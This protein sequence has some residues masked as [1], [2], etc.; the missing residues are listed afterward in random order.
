MPLDMKHKNI[1]ATVSMVRLVG[2]IFGDKSE[3]AEA[4][5]TKLFMAESKECD[6]RVAEAC[7]FNDS[8]Q[9]NLL[10]CIGECPLGTLVEQEIKTTNMLDIEREV[11]SFGCDPESGPFPTCGRRI[12]KDY[13]GRRKYWHTFKNTIL[14]LIRRSK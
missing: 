1:G 5:L 10:C 13:V 2:K 9:P 6:F 8:L 14:R 12:H 11:T 3:R 7:V 4:D